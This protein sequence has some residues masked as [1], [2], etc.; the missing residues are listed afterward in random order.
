[1]IDHF[2][3]SD[4]IGVCAGDWEEDNF[5]TGYDVILF[6]NVAHGRDSKAPMKMAKAFDAMT[7][8]GLL[9]VNDF[10][11]NNERNGPLPAALFNLMV[12]A[13]SEQEMID[14]IRAAGFTTIALIASDPA[15]G[16]GIIT[17]VKPGLK[18]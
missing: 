2:G 5:G 18:T 11:L 15:V 1:V 6:S 8:G 13:F 3:L 14:V 17:A 9:I 7:P 4:R 12:D 16:N 10:L